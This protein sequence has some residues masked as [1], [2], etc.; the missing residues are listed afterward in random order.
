MPNDTVRDVR[1][2]YLRRHPIW[3]ADK[4]IS[5]ADSPIQLRTH[6]K[7]HQLDL[8]IVRQQYILAFN[9]PVNHFTRVEMSQAAK[10]FPANTYRRVMLRK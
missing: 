1:S 2:A 10:D 8:G 3:R 7:V 6:A 9:I 4:R 5:S